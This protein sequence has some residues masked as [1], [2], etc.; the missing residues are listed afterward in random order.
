MDEGFVS[1]EKDNTQIS[2]VQN[3]RAKEFLG[4]RVS[5]AGSIQYIEQIY[6]GTMGIGQV[7]QC[8]PMH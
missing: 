8:S 4:N 2:A 5:E 6:L 3:S 1:V 7:A